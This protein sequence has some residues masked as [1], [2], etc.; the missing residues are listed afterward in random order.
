MQGSTNPSARTTSMVRQITARHRPVKTPAPTMR[1]GLGLSRRSVSPGR[2][3]APTP[4]PPR[5]FV[6]E[7]RRSP[8]VGGAG[9]MPRN[10][11][12]VAARMSAVQRCREAPRVPSQVARCQS[13]EAPRGQQE[14]ANYKS[15]LCP[16][17]E[18]CVSEAN[19]EKI[20]ANQREHQAAKRAKA[21]K[22]GD[23]DATD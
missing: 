22:R 20:R 10:R 19:R 6:L 4:K 9:R 12:A 18:P 5:T 16:A 21:K 17:D 3:P 23:P 15:R 8:P 13:G 11:S 7:N 2:P 1:A 14:V